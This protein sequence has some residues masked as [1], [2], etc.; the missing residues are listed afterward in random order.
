[1]KKQFVYA[2]LIEDRQA[3]AEV[4]IFSTEKKA[5]KFA[6]EVC[7][8]NAKRPDDYDEQELSDFMQKQGWVFYAKYSPQGDCVTVLKREVDDPSD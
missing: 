1:M 4:R 6:K 5:V 3:D 2:L 7:V 8:E